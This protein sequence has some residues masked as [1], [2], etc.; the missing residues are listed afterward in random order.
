[1]SRLQIYTMDTLKA[2]VQDPTGAYRTLINTTVSLKW[3]EGR[4]V[5]VTQLHARTVTSTPGVLPTEVSTG[6]VNT[7]NP[8]PV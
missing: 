1:M 7:N 3:V 2:R 5:S 6:S 4:A 8:P